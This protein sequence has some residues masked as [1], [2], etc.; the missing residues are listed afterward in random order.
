[1][2]RTLVLLKPEALKWG[3]AGYVITELSN[4]RLRLIGAKLV[5]VSKELAETHYKMHK[6]K[7]F[8]DKLVKHLSGYFHNENVLALVYTG[9]NA[10]LRIRGV[11]GATDPTKA[12]PYTIRGRF[13]KH[14]PETDVFENV[15]H[16]SATKEEAE[17][18]IKLWFKPN[19]IIQQ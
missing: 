3:I 8:F 7:H 5:K 11:V 16:A 1:M 19:E 15:I 2:E 17:E 13:G 12:E 10:V 18:E 14:N 9:D 4:T 6:E